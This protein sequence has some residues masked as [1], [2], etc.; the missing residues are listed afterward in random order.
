MPSLMSLYALAKRKQFFAFFVSY[1]RFEAY[2]C[3]VFDGKGK[4]KQGT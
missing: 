2:A 3:A 4:F 1:V